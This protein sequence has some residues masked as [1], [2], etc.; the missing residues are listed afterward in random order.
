MSLTGH[1]LEWTLVC[2]T[3]GMPLLAVTPAAPLTA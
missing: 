3:V 2:S 1:A